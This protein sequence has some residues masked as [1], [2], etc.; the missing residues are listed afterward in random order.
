MIAKPN[1]VLE[2]RAGQV[3][4]PTIEV[5]NSTHWPWKQGCFLGMDESVNLQNMPIDFIN[6]PIDFEVKGQDN[7]KMTVPITVL[8]NA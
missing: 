5:R 6:V 7:F 8:S 4:L 2:A 3:L 1:E